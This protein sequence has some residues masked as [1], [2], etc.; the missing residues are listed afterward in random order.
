[1][2]YDITPQGLTDTLAHIENRRQFIEDE[3]IGKPYFVYEMT[4][5]VSDLANYL[6][7]LPELNDAHARK[8]I[9]EA[10]IAQIEWESRLDG[11]PTA[12]CNAYA[13]VVAVGRDADLS[14]PED[15]CDVYHALLK[16]IDTNAEFREK[17]PALRQRLDEEVAKIFREQE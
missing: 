6:Q 12:L 5:R 7:L 9:A 16:A 3:L 13:A 17:D 2:S 11:M 10:A 15:V 4:C 8:A 14:D 1:M